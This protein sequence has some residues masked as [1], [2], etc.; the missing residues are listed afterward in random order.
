MV[1]GYPR[2]SETFVAQEI[3]GL[4]HRGFELD[5]V[6]LRHPTDEHIHPVHERVRASVLYLPE[7]LHDEPLRVARALLASLRGKR[8]WSTFLLWL[9]HLR[10]DPTRNRL[11]RFG[12]AL[13]LAHEIDPA[14]RLLYGHF[15][16][17]PASVT[18]YAARLLERPF[19]LSAHAKD[20][21][22]TPEPELRE[23]LS[24]ARWTV[25][26]TRTNTEHL[27]R[28]CP[29]AR[30]HLLY[31]GLDLRH[32][33]AAART[34]EQRHERD[35]RDPN[36]PVLILSV[37]RAVEKKGIDDILRTLATL[38]DDLHWRFVHIG[39]GELIDDLRTLAAASGLE[40]RTSWLGAQPRAVVMEHMRQADIFCLLARIAGSGDR[41]GLPNVLLE[42][43]MAGAA[44]LT[45]PMDGIR[46]FVEHEVTGLLTQTDGCARPGDALARLISGP[47]LRR[48]LAM[49]ARA[50]VMERFDASAG[51]DRLAGLLD[52]A[53]AR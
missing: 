23:K 4:E 12:Q 35:G 34:L 36:A 38:P 33:P 25:C 27:R 47:H 42:A 20:I 46:E 45:T 28:L 17:T 8:F 39:G 40:G 48:R 21:W 44:L 52:E 49:A 32:W 31:H 3:E 14:V 2:L 43:A 15:L 13:V 16:H 29:Q 22:T 24:R 30:V 1:K 6:S 41:D 11:R 53:I 7:Y 18:F 26:C 5:I 51:L 19:A 9:A 10:R 37:A 50:K